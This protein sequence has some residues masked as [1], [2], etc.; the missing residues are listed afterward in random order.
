[1]GAC[2]EDRNWQRQPRPQDVK[3]STL[4]I[5]LFPARCLRGDI[6]TYAIAPVNST[7]TRTLGPGYFK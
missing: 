7:V 3:S 4:I 1:M 5:L 2:A 6:G